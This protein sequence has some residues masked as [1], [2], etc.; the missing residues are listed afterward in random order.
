MKYCIEYEDY[1]DCGMST[2]NVTIAIIEEFRTEEELL[3]HLAAYDYTNPK[4][5]LLKSPLPLERKEA[6]IAQPPTIVTYRELGPIKTKEEPQP[7][8]I[9]V[10]YVRKS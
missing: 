3:D 6:K 1:E 5:Y 2:S 10:T 8:K 7:D 9:I 4:V